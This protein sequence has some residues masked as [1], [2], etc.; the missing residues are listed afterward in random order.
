MSLSV[1]RVEFFLIILVRISAFMLSAP[2]FNQKTIPYRVKAGLSFFISMVVF[3]TIEYVPLAYTS[4]VGFMGLVIKEAAIGVSL[5]FMANICIQILDFSGRLIDTE[6]GFS[7]VNVLNPITNVQTSVTGTLYTYLV[8]LVMLVSDMHYFVLSA[9]LDTFEFIPIEGGKLP[10]E[11]YLLVVKFIKEYFIIAF[12]IVLP[13]FASILVVNIVLGI[14]A[15][16]APQ[17]NMF[18]IGM[19]LKVFVG[20]IILFLAIGMLPSITEFIFCEMKYMLSD[21]IKAFSPT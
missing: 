10:P 21:M 6:I 1:E 2:F 5:G 7:M 20:L 18:V 16:I 11:L 15:K 3:N 12:R 8:M 4:T 9:I 17:M 14:L 13:V 19:Q